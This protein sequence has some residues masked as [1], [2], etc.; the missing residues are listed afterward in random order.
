[1]RQVYSE[2]LSKQPLI[3][4]RQQEPVQ[5]DIY[6]EGFLPDYLNDNNFAYQQEDLVRRN[7]LE[8]ERYQRDVE[9]VQR[10]RQ[11]EIEEAQQQQNLA[12]E[13]LPP[14]PPAPPP[15][16]PIERSSSQPASKTTST[17]STLKQKAKEN[18]PP[19]SLDEVL[20]R[21]SELKFK[22]EERANVSHSDDHMLDYINQNGNG[23]YR[24]NGDSFEKELYSRME[25]LSNDDTPFRNRRKKSVY[26]PPQ[27][28]DMT[29]ENKGNVEYPH[30]VMLHDDFRSSNT[31]P[32]GT[33]KTK[34]NGF[35]N[36]PTILGK[37]GGSSPAKNRFEHI[38]N[39]FANHKN[40]LSAK[41]P[42]VVNYGQKPLP[43]SAYVDKLFDPVFAG[44]E[45]DLTNGASLIVS[46]P[47]ID[48]FL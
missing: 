48:I 46:I 8:R 19:Y 33:L 17:S 3:F 34:E 1:M 11:R 41:K 43:V 22:R 9:D 21:S 38:G 5:Q 31:L 47:C 36:P 45:K 18:R 44:E 40:S 26:T 30:I 23:E 24:H 20:E 4:Q 13:R 37:S 27:G 10:H 16:P 42:Y 12:A 29:A 28:G 7:Y 15:P 32:R 14:P 35:K 2:E 39:K 25:E 6:P